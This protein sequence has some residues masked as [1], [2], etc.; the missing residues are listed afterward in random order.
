M[1]FPHKNIGQVS[2]KVKLRRLLW[3]AVYYMLFIPFPTKIFW[4]WRWLLLK[5]FGADVS[6]KAMVYSSVRIWAPWN[7]KMEDYSCLGPHVICYNQDVVELG[8]R[9]VVSQYS[10]LCTAGH[11]SETVN[12]AQSGLII[13]PIKVN[14]CSWIGVRAYLNMGV[15]IGEGAI[16]G[17]TASVYK[18]VEPWTI[19]GGNPAKII[20]HRVK[21]QSVDQK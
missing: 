14:S 16:V 15:E 1:A 7:L 17:A 20:R 2:F 6:F 9:S 3:N 18:D 11:D 4:P 13:A 8:E 10:F 19:V 21:I 5:F 12:N